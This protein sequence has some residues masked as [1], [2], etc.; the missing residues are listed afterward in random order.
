GANM[1]KEGES[2][3]AGGAASDLP[4]CIVTGGAGTL[5]VMYQ[6]KSFPICCSGCRDEFNEN[7]DKYVKKYLARMEKGEVKEGQPPTTAPATSTEKTAE[8]KAIPKEE[9]AKTKT[10]SKAETTKP[11]TEKKDDPAA[12]AASLLAQGTALEKAGKASAALDYYK[13]V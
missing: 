4:K 9:A 3:A 6:G 10:T 11:A 2:F 7:P 1:G 8:A 13:R 12:K 5:T